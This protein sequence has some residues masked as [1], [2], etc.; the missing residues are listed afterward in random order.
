[1]IALGRF[2]KLFLAGLF[3]MALLPL[4]IKAEA[5]LLIRDREA[6]AIDTTLRSSLNMNSSPWPEFFSPPVQ[7]CIKDGIIN[8]ESNFKTFG[9][10]TIRQQPIGDGAGFLNF[11][12]PASGQ[13]KIYNQYEALSLAQAAGNNETETLGQRNDRQEKVKDNRQEK[14]KDNRQ[15]ERQE[16]PAF[17][18]DEDNMRL[19]LE[20]VLVPN[21]SAVISSPRDGQI[22][23]IFVQD[24]DLFEAG[25]TLLKYNCTEVEARLAALEER[26]LLS[27]TKASSGAKLFKLDLISNV[28]NLSF[29]AERK[30]ILAQVT[31]LREDRKRCFI[32]GNYDGRVIKRLANPGEFT[33]SDRVLM[34]V[35]SLEN[36]QAEFLMP[37]LWLRWVNV[38]A[39]AEI[40]LHETGKLYKAQVS[41]I[42][43]E[44]D[45]VSQTIKVSARLDG[46]KDPLLPGMSGE[47]ILDL[48][49]IR[50][51]G[52]P[53]F[54]IEPRW[55]M[56]PDDNKDRD[57]VDDK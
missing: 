31:A 16:R 26:A 5:D 22:K 10:N 14:V 7:I 50:R 55:E 17:P 18:Y 36:L 32:K 8:A 1:M 40:K 23:D 42:T 11:L 24:G 19:T 54:L 9:A 6:K 21:K 38:G 29:Q 33:R 41:R 34:E 25:Q 30:E 15:D 28:E 46:Y 12:A 35:A 39:P 20:T 49:K 52:L 4:I 57:R 48:N 44:V 13:S 45:P 47:I 37:S 56:N 51:T 27:G 43:G 3:V 53:G 2:L